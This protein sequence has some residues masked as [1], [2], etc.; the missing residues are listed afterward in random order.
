MKNIFYKLK[1][2]FNKE[3]NTIENS[4]F[5]TTNKKTFE[6]YVNE[7]PKFSLDALIGKKLQ[8]KIDFIKSVN[9]KIFLEKIEVTTET[10]E[11]LKKLQNEVLVECGFELGN[12]FENAFDFGDRAIAKANLNDCRGAIEDFNQAILMNPDYENAYLWRG[13]E[14][15]KIGNIEGALNDFNFVLKINPENPEAL[16]NIN[17]VNLS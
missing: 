10:I 13:E 7:I 3:T 1:N 2:I 4:N 6:E 12:S 8:E 14:K 17:K 5:T 9:N 11:N 15:L 16:I